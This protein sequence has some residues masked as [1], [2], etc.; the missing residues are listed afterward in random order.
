[1]FF[2][3]RRHDRRTAEDF[4][5]EI[6]SHLAL[7]TQRLVEE[8]LPPDEARAAARR[9]FGNVTAAQERFHERHPREWFVQLWRDHVWAA[10]R[11]AKHRAF[12]I[13]V[14]LTLGLAIGGNAAIYSVVSSV[15]LKPLPYPDPD[16]L[17]QVFAQHP[18]FADLPACAAWR[19]R[20][21]T[22]PRP[23]A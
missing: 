6:E 3:R 11:L 8:G 9:R 7:E 5:T 10:R 19:V 17:V 14:T 16:R 12:T 13:V 15:L 23:R 21:T 1:M 18:R 2:F 20:K 22:V 4:S